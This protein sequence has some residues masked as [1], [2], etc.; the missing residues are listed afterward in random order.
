MGRQQ[1]EGVVRA[2]TEVSNSGRSGA[3]AHS[4]VQEEMWTCAKRFTADKYTESIPPH[5][6]QENEDGYSS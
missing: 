5:P 6:F 1:L 3:P 2:S 4:F